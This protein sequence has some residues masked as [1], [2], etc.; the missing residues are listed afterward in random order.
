MKNAVK[1]VVVEAIGEKSF[2]DFFER[3]EGDASYDAYMPKMQLRKSLK[4]FL[5]ASLDV[6]GDMAG[7]VFH[8][9]NGNVIIEA[10]HSYDDG[11]VISSSYALE[12][13]DSFTLDVKC[14]LEEVFDSS[15]KEYNLYKKYEEEYDNLTFIHN[16]RV[17]CDDENDRKAFLEKEC[18]YVTLVTELRH[19]IE[20][21]ARKINCP[22][23]VASYRKHFMKYCL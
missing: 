12:D 8:L 9:I 7:I 18:G 10:Y 16:L 17:Q 19:D 1:S 13:I 11:F 3:I 15:L 21:Y 4:G 6:F 5:D 20:E 23:F 14:F 22:K 2:D